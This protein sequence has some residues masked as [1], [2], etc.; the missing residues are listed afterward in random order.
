[1]YSKTWMMVGALFLGTAGCATNVA[2]GLDDQ[3]DGVDSAGDELGYKSEPIGFGEVKIA[4]FGCAPVCGAIGSKSEGWRDGCSGALIKW[5]QCSESA[6]Y[7]G[8]V[9]TADEGWYST[10]GDLIKKTVCATP[11]K[12]N[13]VRAYTFK[14]SAG[15]HID[16]YVDGLFEREGDTEPGLDTRARLYL[17]DK[18]IATSDDTTEP[19]WILRLNQAPNAH[20]SNLSMALPADGEYTLVVTSKGNRQGSAEVVVKTP[21]VDFCATASDFDE[22][23]NTTFFGARNFDTEADAQA[24]LAQT[25]PTADA[26]SVIAG[27]C[28]EPSM[29]A[30]VYEPVCAQ[31]AAGIDQQFGNP[32]EFR[33]A[34]LAEAGDETPME[35][36]GKYVPGE[37]NDVDFCAVAIMQWPENT[38]TYVYVKNFN[39]EADAQTWFATMQPA[40][41]ESYVQPG[42]CNEPKKCPMYWNP[43]CG[44]VLYDDPVTFSNLCAFK[45]AVAARAGDEYPSENKGFY[46]MGQC[47]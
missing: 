38:D 36:K 28:Y 10:S 19:G 13:Q 1:M 29:C 26:T 11:A 18:K 15:Q 24:W 45:A 23:S 3:D 12:K 17:G 33:N 5:A 39:D 32:C 8:Q 47:E 21:D 25:W 35:S 30:E 41:V 14:A 2:T 22:A 7:C 6:S 43:V 37:C 27:P 9:N 31:T 20:S 44:Q 16:L 34:V 40:P 4:T 46:H 42:A